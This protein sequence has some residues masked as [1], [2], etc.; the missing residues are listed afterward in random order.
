MKSNHPSKTINPIPPQFSFDYQE[1]QKD[2]ERWSVF[3]ALPIVM[4]LGSCFDLADKIHSG[5]IK[6]PDFVT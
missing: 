1:A 6:V 4:Q 2:F 5:A 3:R